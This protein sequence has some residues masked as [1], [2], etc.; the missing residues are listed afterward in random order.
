[1]TLDSDNRVQVRTL[2][3]FTMQA[4]LWMA[5]ETWYD[6][7]A[8]YANFIVVDSQPGYFSFWEPGRLIKKYFGKPARIYR[9]GPYTVLVWHR[10]LLLSIPANQA[11]GPG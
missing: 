2:S 6:P 8:H 11:V 5:N 3:Q 9:F 4:D 10:N 7:R 1:V